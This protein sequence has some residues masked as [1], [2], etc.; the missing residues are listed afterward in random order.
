VIPTPGE[1]A[2]NPRARSGRM[3]AARRLPAEGAL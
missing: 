2:D 1:V 3:R